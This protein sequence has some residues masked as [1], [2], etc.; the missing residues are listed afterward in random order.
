MVDFAL[1]LLFFF[2]MIWPVS[3][4]PLIYRTYGKTATFY[5][6]LLWVM[7]M[8]GYI[9]ACQI[10]LHASEKLQSSNSV[11]ASI[12]Q[13]SISTDVLL[14][15]MVIAAILGLTFIVAKRRHDAYTSHLENNR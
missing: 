14:V 11:A 9:L 6:L 12:G 2:F 3:T 4:L 5:G 13:M 7:L 15:G 1:L 8:S 10:A